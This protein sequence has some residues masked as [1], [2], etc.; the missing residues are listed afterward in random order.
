MLEI[1]LLPKQD[2]IGLAKPP[3]RFVDFSFECGIVD[4][5]LVDIEEGHIIKRDLV[6]KDDELHQIG[7]GL[8]PK[9]FLAAPEEVIQEGGDVVGQSVCVTPRQG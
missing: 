2:G 7:V 4:R 3:F 1:L 8:L 6:K 5:A 9:G